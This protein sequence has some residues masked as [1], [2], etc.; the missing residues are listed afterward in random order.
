MGEEKKKRQKKKFE[1]KL[2]NWQSLIDGFKQ[3][4]IGLKETFGIF[5]QLG[6]ILFLLLRRMIIISFQDIIKLLLGFLSYSSTKEFGQW[7]WL[8][9]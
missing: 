9:W 4:Q 8:I 7:M 5:W 2:C 6:L 3:I 1:P